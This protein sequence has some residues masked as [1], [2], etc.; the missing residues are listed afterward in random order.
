[1]PNLVRSRALESKGDR[2]SS[3]C[4][5]VQYVCANG[6]EMRSSDEKAQVTFAREQN[7]KTRNRRRR[8]REAQGK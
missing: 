5:Q 7:T 1:M 6:L 4:E 2:T 8:S 3:I